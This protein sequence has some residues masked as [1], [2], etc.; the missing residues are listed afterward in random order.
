GATVTAMLMVAAAFALTRLAVPGTT[1]GLA[2]LV[3]AGIVLDAGVTTNLVV[4]QRAIFALGADVR[5][6]LNGLFIAAFFAGGAIGSALGGYVFAEGGWPGVAWVGLALPL[7][8]LAWFAT[9]R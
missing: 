6:R 5:S 2:I 3:V 8:A 9:E 7:A 1:A 4:G